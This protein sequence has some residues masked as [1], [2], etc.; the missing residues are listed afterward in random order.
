[1]GLTRTRSAVLQGVI[2]K[3]VEVEANIGP[4]LPGTY[5]VGMP[6]TAIAEARD[7]MKTA[8][9]NLGLQ[10]PKSKI[11]L[12]LSPAS[13]PKSGAQLDLAMCV[14]ILA[15]ANEFLQRSGKIEQTIFLGEV[16]LDGRIKQVPGILPALV[17]AQEHGIQQAV[18]P[19]D[20]VGETVV[21]DR[22][23]VYG[24]N[25]IQEVLQWLAGDLELVPAQEMF[26]DEPAE[27]SFDDPEEVLDLQ[28][29]AGQTAAKHAL[30]VAAAGGHH[31]MMV[32]PPG[33]GKSMLAAS[34]PGIL[35]PLEPKEQ[36]ATT[37]IHSVAA[38]LRGRV[39]THAPFIAPHHCISRAALV[40]G[41]SGRPTP[42]AVS[43]AHHGVLFLDE[44]S[45]MPASILDCLRTPLEERVVRLS[46][47][48]GDVEF[49]ARFQLVLAANPCPCAAEDWKD[50]SCHPRKRQQHLSNISGPLKDRLD[51]FVRTY[52]K[53][54]S[55]SNTETE[56][57]AMVAAR[58]AAA[59]SRS[60]KRWIYHGIGDV[61]NAEI[62]G[63]LLRKRFPATEDAMELLAA[64]L[65]MG[66]ISQRAVD[67][68]LKLA[69]TLADL[70]AVDTPTLDHIARALELRGVAAMPGTD[71]AVA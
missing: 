41:G 21:L 47:S 32:G 68:S 27:L 50:C 36:L 12:N 53:G 31:L 44:V 10:W 3:I 48:H 49:P 64:Y 6:D 63:H 2:G 11:I 45:E 22:P 51:I 5:I 9:M 24:V 52:G 33:S 40:G 20:N 57:S 34:L 70:E 25:H 38:G 65:S 55:L 19:M 4:G 13:L 30:E 1:M 71:G 18:I 17:A 60:R 43:L 16:G 46:R 61:F 15:N 7:R 69:W 23:T 35:P 42:G 8:V 56:T 14:A 62:P 26:C 67:R 59:R 37:A 58:V 29:I 54:S 39:L 28:Y 66:E